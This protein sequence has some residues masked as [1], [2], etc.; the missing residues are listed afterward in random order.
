MSIK[1]IEA[2]FPLVS[3]KQT[4]KIGGNVASLHFSAISLHKR[5]PYGLHAQQCTGVVLKPLQVAIIS[6]NVQSVD[7][8][9]PRNENGDYIKRKYTSLLIFLSICWLNL[10]HDQ[11]PITFDFIQQVDQSATVQWLSWIGG[12]CVFI[13][14]RSS[15]RYI[16]IFIFLS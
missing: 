9:S 4:S 3:T 12:K 15:T 13:V 10:L 8:L 2:T 7:L 5:I 1:V 14:R 11:T 6:Y 16:L